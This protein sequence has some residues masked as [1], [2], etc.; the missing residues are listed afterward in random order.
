[1]LRREKIIRIHDHGKDKQVKGHTVRATEVTIQVDSGS[2]SGKKTTIKHVLASTH[3]MLTM[4]A[5]CDR[6]EQMRSD[7]T[8]VGDRVLLT[9]PNHYSLEGSIIRKVCYDLP[10]E[11]LVIVWTPSM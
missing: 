7:E 5:G 9:Y 4:R 1:M 10:L 11:D 3:Y 6:F 2:A 8:L